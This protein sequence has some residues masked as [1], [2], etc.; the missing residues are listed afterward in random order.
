MSKELE[1]KFVRADISEELAEQLLFNV[2]DL[3]LRDD[4]LEL[5]SAKKDPDQI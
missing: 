1:I 5:V 3:L 2:F 4:N